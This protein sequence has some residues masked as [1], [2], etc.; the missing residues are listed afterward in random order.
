MNVKVNFGE[1]GNVIIP[2][3]LPRGTI[4]KSFCKDDSYFQRSG[5]SEIEMPKFADGREVEVEVRGVAIPRRVLHK[6]SIIDTFESW[7]MLGT[8]NQMMPVVADINKLMKL[9]EVHTFVAQIEADARRME[10]L[11]F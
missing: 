11:L 10:G 8:H 3:G 9:C 2:A 4:G 5:F 7:E 6:D 1:D